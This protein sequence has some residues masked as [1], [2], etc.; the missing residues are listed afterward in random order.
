M[1]QLVYSVTSAA[2]YRDGQGVFDDSCLRPEVS[3]PTLHG[4][5][6]DASHIQRCG[7]APLEALCSL[8]LTP[9]RPTSGR[10][11]AWRQA[12]VEDFAVGM[13]MNELAEAEELFGRVP[14]A[15]RRRD[16]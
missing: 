10:D 7:H 6:V 16:P 11:A 2:G 12:G 9:E 5:F 3:S 4:Q 1:S 14:G 15:V 8:R 13:R